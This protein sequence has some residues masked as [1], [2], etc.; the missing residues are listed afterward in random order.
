M[1]VIRFTEKAF[2]DLGLLKANFHDFKIHEIKMFHIDL[3][4]P[5]IKDEKSP[6]RTLCINNN[7]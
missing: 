3:E 1:T 4:F 7:H 2:G 6:Q 5:N